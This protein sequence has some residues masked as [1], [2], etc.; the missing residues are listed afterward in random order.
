VNRLSGK[1]ALITGSS[2]GIGLSIAK[3]LADAGCRV[4][5]NGRDKDRLELCANNIKGAIALVGDV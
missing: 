3:A 2:K 1:S 4:A 5:I